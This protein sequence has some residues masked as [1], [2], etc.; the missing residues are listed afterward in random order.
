MSVSQAPWGNPPLPCFLAAS[1]RLH[2]SPP[3]RVTSPQ[4][5]DVQIGSGEP[6][7]LMHIVPAFEQSGSSDSRSGPFP[8]WERNE[9]RSQDEHIS[10]LFV[11]HMCGF[12]GIWP[13]RGASLTWPGWA[14]VWDPHHRR[15]EE[16]PLGSQE[17]GHVVTCQPQSPEM[18][19]FF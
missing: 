16:S 4:C 13:G 10:L 8:L 19:N 2:L 3:L 6:I 1:G 7:K 11:Y 14:S 9:G 12:R 17:V 5:A 18:C 15:T